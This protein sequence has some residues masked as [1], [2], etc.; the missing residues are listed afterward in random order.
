MAALASREAQAEVG[1]ST[2]QAM[3]VVFRARLLRASPLRLKVQHVRFLP[4]GL[5]SANLSRILA[6]ALKRSISCSGPSLHR[7]RD[8]EKSATQITVRSGQSCPYPVRKVKHP[9]TAERCQARFSQCEVMVVMSSLHGC[10][11]V[12]GTKSRKIAHQQPNDAG[13]AMP[14]LDFRE[15]KAFE[16]AAETKNIVAN[17]SYAC[18]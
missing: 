9:R 2:Q 15:S 7:G 8:S 3:L 14:C 4:P 17:A 16:T 13:A 1:N 18:R 5:M 10:N 6:R 12:F 11:I